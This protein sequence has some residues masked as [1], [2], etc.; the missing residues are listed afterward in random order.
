MFDAQRMFP[1]ARIEKGAMKKDGK[2]ESPEPKYNAEINQDITDAISVFETSEKNDADT[3]QL[4]NAIFKLKNNASSD[5]KDFNFSWNAEQVDKMI[6]IFN[7]SYGRE[8]SPVNNRNIISRLFSSNSAPKG[9]K[10]ASDYFADELAEKI[11]KGQCLNP[12]MEKEIQLWAQD[13]H[14]ISEEARMA[15]TLSLIRN[16]G[17]VSDRILGEIIDTHAFYGSAMVRNLER[18]F[19][20][21]SGNISQTLGIID[22]FESIA[23]RN[24]WGTDFEG[25][26]AQAL[27]VLERIKFQ[28]KNYF[29]AER[30]ELLSQFLQQGEALKTKDLMSKYADNNLAKVAPEP[31]GAKFYSKPKEFTDKCVTTKI[32]KKYGAVYNP[33]GEIDSFFLANSLSSSTLRLEDILEKEGAENYGSMDKKEKIFLVDNYKALLSLPFRDK[34][35]NEFGIKIDQ[36]NIREQIQFVN[37]LSQKTISEVFETKTAITG[38]KKETSKM[39][40]LKSFLSLECDNGNGDRIIEIAEKLS[41]ENC[42]KIFGKIAE[43]TDLAQEKDEELAIVALKDSQKELPGGVQTELLRKAH[44]IILKFSTELE[45]STQASEGRIRKLLTDLE[46]SRI[47]IETMAALLVATKKAGA[48]QS[49][50]GIKGMEMET[51]GEIELMENETLSHKLREMYRVNNSHKSKDDLERL[52]SDFE[53]HKKHDPR[54][55]LV[56]FDK[57]NK[58]NPKKS[59]EN[60][61]GF[62]RSSGCITKFEEQPLVELPEG[63]RYLG[64][65]NIDPILQKFYFGENF[66]REIM[67]KEFSSGTKKLIAHVPENGPSHKITKLLGF[68]T[69]AEEGDYR[70]DAGNIIAKRL[71]VELARG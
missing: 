47:D 61:V 53:T 15:L 8:T 11:R 64:A 31:R 46:K 58:E 32:D 27:D 6:D 63:E 14:T 34:V 35:E 59:L 22:I 51:I 54:F 68:E 36:L 2:L 30:L 24:G 17:I 16:P 38:L 52:L 28:N 3:V 41:V 66:L 7:E 5:A 62:M 10:L 1:S 13:I 48:E 4:L 50:S 60:L 40:C 39:T 69:V 45:N 55:H 12:G 57:D 42:E 19:N 37:F 20:E 26:I 9:E 21:A 25:A 56:Y 18:Q 67:E 70:D 23:K 65:M 43:L 29:V 33:Q 49:V 44:Q 71:R